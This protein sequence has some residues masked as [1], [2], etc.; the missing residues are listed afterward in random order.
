MT[1]FRGV[2]EL[3]GYQLVRLQERHCSILYQWDLKE[4][5]RDL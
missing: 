4:P 3:L 2:V 1:A 5:R